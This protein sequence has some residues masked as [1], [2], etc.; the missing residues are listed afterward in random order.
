MSRCENKHPT[1]SNLTDS[2][3]LF[4]MPRYLLPC[5]RNNGIERW[6]HKS[7]SCSLDAH[8]PREHSTRRAFYT[9]TDATA[10]SNSALIQYDGQCIEVNQEQMAQETMPIIPPR[11]VHLRTPIE[12]IVPCAQLVVQEND[13]KPQVFATMVDFYLPT[14]TANHQVVLTDKVDAKD[15]SADHINDKDE[16][17]EEIDAACLSSVQSTVEPGILSNSWAN[18]G[19]HS[20]VPIDL[21]CNDTSSNVSSIPLN[22]RYSTL[23]I[24]S[25]ITT[26]T[27]SNSTVNQ[28]VDMHPAF[29]MTTLYRNTGAS[30][31]L[32]NT[33]TEKFL[34]ITLRMDE[35]GFWNNWTRKS[36]MK[37]TE[38]NHMVQIE[39]NLQLAPVCFNP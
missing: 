36:P 16:A 27:V 35:S 17:Q 39:L 34:R 11:I 28:V 18:A 1:L 25:K 31:C 2:V 32:A 12:M 21:L 13:G 26:S 9:M 30:T 3:D 7:A 22:G 20:L 23:S 6:T 19:W 24:V 14:T 15:C 37:T 5:L 29:Q 10:S 33:D 38:I 4:R 8:T